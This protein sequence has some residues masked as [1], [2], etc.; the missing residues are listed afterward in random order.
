VTAPA[1][2]ARCEP[3]GSR[4]RDVQQAGVGGLPTLPGACSKRLRAGRYTLRNRIPPECADTVRGSE[5][6]ASD[7]S[8]CVAVDSNATK[9]PWPLITGLVLWMGAQ[10]HQRVC[11][12]FDGS[13]RSSS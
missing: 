12:T 4:R 3:E 9:L 13:R 1:T 11:A 8:E 7:Q 10:H 6:S 2:I 5:F